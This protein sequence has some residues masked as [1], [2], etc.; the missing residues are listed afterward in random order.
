MK[1]IALLAKGASVE[2]L[3]DHAVACDAL[4]SINDALRV[5]PDRSFEYCF[6]SDTVVCEHLIKFDDRVRTYVARE[7]INDGFDDIPQD[8]KAKLI[9]Y[10]ERTCDGDIDSLKNRILSGGVCHHSTVPAAIHWLCKNTPYEQMT[11]IG[12][13]GGGAYAK[14]M[15]HHGD[16]DLYLWRVV[17]IRTAA[18]CENVYGKKIRFLDARSHPS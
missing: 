4:A 7:P 11:V 18:I 12:V 15:W 10:P 2:R 16:Q 6:F 9:T 1:S 13:D 5:L 17:A 3:L 8:I 14:D